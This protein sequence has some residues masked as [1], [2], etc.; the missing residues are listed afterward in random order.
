MTGQYWRAQTPEQLQQCFK[1][2]SQSMPARG[3]RITWEEW[4]DRRS[5]GQNAFQHKIYAE[6]S[7]YLISRGRTDCSETWVKDMLKNKF[8]G[9]EDRE[10]VD[11]KTGEVT[12]RQCLRETSKLDTG[13]AVHYTDQILAWAGEIGCEIKIPTMCDYRKYK[14][15]Q[16]A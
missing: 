12:V 2:L 14:E 10:F 15:M 5:L 4:R 16:S 1:F 13:E 11:I 3:L 7:Q 8:L 6:I 9:W